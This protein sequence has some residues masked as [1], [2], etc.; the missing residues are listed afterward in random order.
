MKLGGI[1]IKPSIMNAAGILSKAPILKK[2]APYLGAVVSKSFSLKEN[3][4]NENP[5]V[6]KVN[7]GLINCIGLSNPGADE[8]MKEFLEARISKP[9][10]FSLFEKNPERLARLAEKV[11]SYCDAVELNFSCPNDTDVCT[12]GASTEGVERYLSRVRDFFH[13]PIVVKLGPT[14]DVLE[15]AKIAEN[16]GADAVTAINTFPAKSPVISGGLSGEALKKRALPTVRL[17]SQELSIPIIG[18]GGIKDSKDVASF[19]KAGASAVQV[20]TAFM[21]ISTDKIGPFVRSLTHNLPFERKEKNHSYKKYTIKSIVNQAPGVKTFVFD[22]SIDA[23]AGQYCFLMLPSLG[24]KPF[25]YSNLSP[26]SIT[27]KAVGR[28]TDKLVKMKRGDSLFMRGPYGNGFP[29]LGGRLIAV[30]GGVGISPLLPFARHYEDEII[31]VM[32]VKSS[33][34]IVHEND[35]RRIGKLIIA[36]E[37]GSNGVKGSVIDALKKIRLEKDDHIIS[38]GPEMM[39]V[40]LS[41]YLPNKINPCNVYFSIERYMKCG[42]GL[43]GACEC[44]GRRVCVDGPVFSLSALQK[45]GDFGRWKRSRSGKRVN[46]K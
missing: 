9:I 11:E 33:V 23:C 4:G 37:D 41:D 16:S 44:S 32:G 26:L 42:M 24:E 45:M 14:L 39:L 7:N 1:T 35:F 8:I 36:T 38:A 31:T 25:S 20:G 30:G 12:I 2:A 28:F 43:C 3:K 27:V 19:M 34:D 21:D 46:V 29:P 6:H 40:G 18:C 13:K 15:I 22:E 17:L 10:I 5:V